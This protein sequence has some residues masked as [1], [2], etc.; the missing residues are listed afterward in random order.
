MDGL[1]DL[2]CV[3]EGEKHL[4]PCGQSGGLRRLRARETVYSC[5]LDSPFFSTIVFLKNRPIPWVSGGFL[6]RR[7][8]GKNGEGSPRFLR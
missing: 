1:V 5:D 2:S 6:E 3:G 8:P 7:I 4:T